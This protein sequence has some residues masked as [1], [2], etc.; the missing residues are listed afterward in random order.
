MK[1]RQRKT[2]DPCQICFMHKDLCFCSQ[3]PSLTLKTRISLVVHYKELKRTSNTGRLAITALK[4]SEMIIRGREQEE[5]SDLSTL[6]SDHYQTI[7]LYP[8]G[9]AALLD[10]SF[11]KNVKKP[12]HLIVPDGNWRQA[13]KVNVRHPELKDVVR[14]KLKPQTAAKEFLRKEHIE[15]G[16]A[17]LEAIAMAIGV[18]E[19]TEAEAKLMNL[20]Q[21]KLQ[22]TLIARGQ[23]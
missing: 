14:V 22:Q 16:M 21:L 19:G 18:L 1:T 8:S 23:K 10:E 20:Y 6:L 17:T 5:R 13:G 12:I 11:L 3:I 4:N 7:L 15:G 2:K 9:D